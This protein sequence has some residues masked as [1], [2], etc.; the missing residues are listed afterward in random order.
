MSSR[1]RLA[2]QLPRS[3]GVLQCEYET[4]QDTPAGQGSKALRWRMRLAWGGEGE[5]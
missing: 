2:L 1:W 4:R 3:R 5:L